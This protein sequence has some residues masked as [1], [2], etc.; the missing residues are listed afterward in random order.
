MAGNFST[1]M[2]DATMSSTVEPWWEPGV[3]ASTLQGNVTATGYPPPPFSTWQI[4]FISFLVLVAAVVTAG[5]N[6]LVMISF[7]VNRQLQTVSNYFLLSLSIADCCIGLISMPLYTMFLIMNYWPLGPLVCDI[8]LSIDYTMSNASVAN[9]LIICFDRYFSVTRPL[10]YRA[11]RTPKKAGIM[12]A[13]AWVLSVLMWTPWIM[14]WPYIEGKRTVAPGNCEIQF[15][16]TNQY[17]TIFT[18]VGAFFLPVIIMCVLYFKIYLETERRQR[19]LRRLQ[20]DRAAYHSR[21]MDS[22]E[23]DVYA[24]LHNK[25]DSSPEAHYSANGNIRGRHRGWRCI[26]RLKHCCRIDRDNEYA[27]EEDSSDP[28]CSPACTPTSS[29]HSHPH[30]IHR[31]EPCLLNG[32]QK[33]DSSSLTIPLINVASNRKS[34]AGAAGA[35][36][37][38]SSATVTPSTTFSRVTSNLSSVMTDDT[39][40]SPPPGGQQLHAIPE[41]RPPPSPVPP[42]GRKSSKA[43]MYTIVIKLPEEGSK[44]GKPSITMIPE[45]EDS[46]DL[47]SAFCERLEEGEHIPMSRRGRAGG[48]QARAGIDGVGEGDG[49][50]H[51]V[52]HFDG[53]V[54]HGE[55][56]TVHYLEDTPSVGRR[57]TQTGN[58][59]QLAMQARYAAKMA[60]NA[61]DQRA[62]KK[63]MEKKQDKKAAKTLSAILFLFIITWTPYNIF[64]VINV[65]CSTCI[66]G[67]LYAIGEYYYYYY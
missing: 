48:D 52:Q 47:D 53:E 23:D 37:E 25:Q 7:C 26:E 35:G 30:N 41:T 33:S 9:L 66:D 40:T 18:C 58:A 31:N 27:D 44:D 49:E 17:I 3:N 16:T 36:N 46:D 43:D 5:G 34:G 32:K 51:V 64:T 21:K 22:S 42:A 55:D 6:I 20:A 60:S 62:R 56:G 57:L 45:H 12:I 13:T 11:G 50:V 8:W 10:T 59:L 38:Q 67:R 15:L 19:D 63:R 24:H 54:V 14:A 4:V 65:F 1:M 61:K 29:L 2:S 28:P 39:P